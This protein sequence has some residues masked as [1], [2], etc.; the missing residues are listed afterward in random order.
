MSEA[1]YTQ[2]WIH[3][4]KERKIEPNKNKTFQ[5]TLSFSRFSF[6]SQFFT[7]LD[8][9]FLLLKPSLPMIQRGQNIATGKSQI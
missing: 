7:T 8:A 9:F 3:G 4:T 5:A 1:W 6:P 2:F